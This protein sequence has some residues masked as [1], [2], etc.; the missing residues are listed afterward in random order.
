MIRELLEETGVNVSAI[1]PLLAPDQDLDFAFKNNL[2]AEITAEL[3]GGYERSCSLY[4]LYSN[5][6]IAAPNYCKSRD[7]VVEYTDDG[8][9]K[10]HALYLQGSWLGGRESL[11]HARETGDYED[12]MAL[13]FAAKSVNVVLTPEKEETFKVLVK[14]DGEYLNE[15]NKGED[16][17]IEDDGRSFL[18][19]DK[20]RLYA[21]V[22]APEYGTYELEMS[23]NSSDF[24]VF[25]FT[26][27][28]Y[29]EGI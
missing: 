29:T 8:T 14:L 4:S 15:F 17:I 16:V 6:Y 27:G 23:S 11:K 12:Y 18:I 24:A 2:G 25:A 21:V 13:R 7:Q 22:E 1:T 3:Y 20:P 26:F 5:S 10:T 19:V 9:R 28:V